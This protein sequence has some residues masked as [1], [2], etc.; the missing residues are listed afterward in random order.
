MGRSNIPRHERDVIPCTEVGRNVD[1]FARKMHVEKCY[2]LEP[3][4][5]SPLT[6]KPIHLC[7]MYHMDTFMTPCLFYYK[8]IVLEFFHTMTT[9]NDPAPKSLRFS[10]YG[11]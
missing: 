8:Q 11:K 10:I 1:Y 2:D 9:G 6:C 3:F 7:Q 5:D 4:S